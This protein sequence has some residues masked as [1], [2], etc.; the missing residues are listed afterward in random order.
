ME[1]YLITAKGYFTD[2]AERSWLKDYMDNDLRFGYGFIYLTG[3][4]KDLDDFLDK[5]IKDG[6]KYIG[7]HTFNEQTQQYE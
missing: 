3:T 1:K 7:L 5:M 6:V 4:R 2:A